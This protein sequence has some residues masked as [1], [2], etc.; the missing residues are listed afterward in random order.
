MR[1]RG[2]ENRIVPVCLSKR[3]MKLYQF[4]PGDATQQLTIVNR[5][6]LG[7]QLTAVGDCPPPDPLASP[8]SGHLPRFGL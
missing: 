2:D 4:L 7:R 3:G 5:I 8:E 6:F 1:Q